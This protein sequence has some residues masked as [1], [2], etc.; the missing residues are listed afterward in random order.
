MPRIDA[1]LR[2]MEKLSAQGAVLTSGQAIVLRFP[3]GD[4]NATQLVA[5]DQ[6]VAMIREIATP[7]ALAAVDG[8]K[9]TVFEFDAGTQTYRF[10]VAPRPGHW[11]VQI[12]PAAPALRAPAALEPAEF[13]GDMMI[14][15]TNYDADDLEAPTGF[16]AL[17]VAARRAGASDLYL[18][19][20]SPPLARVGGELVPL[21]S[22]PV[23][24]EAIESD[25]SAL[26]S[27]EIR[28][29]WAAQG[30]VV[31]SHGGGAGGRLRIHWSR[32]R[33][34]AGASIRLVAAEPAALD[35]L[36]LPSGLEAWVEAPRGLLLLAGERGSGRTT[37]MAALLGH[38]ART[39]PAMVVTI[40]QPVEV[41]IPSGRGLVS[42]R[43]VGP[44]LRTVGRG[45]TAAA[46][47]GADVI[48]VGHLPDGSAA[49]AAIEAAQGGALVLVTVAA[50]SAAAAIE[51]VISLAERTP[52]GAGARV[53]VSDALLGVIAQGIDGSGPQR[54]ARFEALPS[55]AEVGELIRAGRTHELTGAAAG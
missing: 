4:R 12:A 32:D 14:E 22:R 30:E 48:G 18:F 5:H 47:G 13:G 17:A 45:I 46:R 44:H 16:D 38:V 51:R 35:R 7:P 55:S 3:D 36:G 9:P 41:I 52:A 6:L 28:T 10:D 40:E 19:A 33:R 21:G 27:T 11:V 8:N 20:D 37:T 43:E 24:G 15:R 34:G 2:S 42:Q 23:D 1:Y 53:L 50:A 25:L 29:A 39:R 49:L 54:R 26:V 31:F